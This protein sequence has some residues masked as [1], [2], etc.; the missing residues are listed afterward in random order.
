MIHKVYREEYEGL[1]TGLELPV[2]GDMNNGHRHH[3]GAI[4]D[5]F[6]A[7]EEQFVALSALV[8]KI[9]EKEIEEK[10]KD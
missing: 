5:R 10:R 1:T 3:L 7:I 8:E 2:R 9:A 6:L 4:E